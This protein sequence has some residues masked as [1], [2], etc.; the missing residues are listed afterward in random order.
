MSAAAS[1][2]KGPTGTTVG[3]LMWRRFRRNRLGFVSG[4][5]VLA[6]YTVMLAAEFFAPYVHTSTH[7]AFTNAP[8]QAVRWLH[9]GGFMWRPFVYPISG[10][11]DRVRFRRTYTQDTERPMP[12]RFFVRGDPYRL[13]GVIPWDVH[14]IGVDEGTLFLFGTDHR[15]RDL[16]ARVLVGGR[17]SLT[18]GLFGV[19]V[20]V[21]LG[22]IIGAV[23]GLAGGRIDNVTQRSIEVL[24]SFPNIPLWMALSAAIPPDWSPIAVFSAIVIVLAILEWPLLAR[25]VRG[26]V[27]SMREAD[28]VI[29]ADALGATQ[30]RIVF[31][32]VI[33][34][35]MSHVIVI[36]T[37]TMP[38]M[39]LA[40][41]TLSFFGLGIQPPMISWGVLLQQAQN[42][43]TLVIYPWR[44]IPG[45]MLFFT[46][47][48]FNFVGDALRDA[49]DPY[50]V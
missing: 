17:I 38:M 21:V 29:A 13:F 28:F 40:E 37:L 10:E 33:P 35:I 5:F 18:I 44:L 39:I 6:L 49:F 36:A 1:D 9:D 24:Q 26:K 45:L 42:L 19:L 30:S 16:L 3:Q 25:E 12:I 4:I 41:S 32:H 46:L 23:S 34:N 14:F 50:S 27:L 2:A 20:A 7:N 43:E 8:P 48:A 11:L 47:L 31:R 22:S 15:G